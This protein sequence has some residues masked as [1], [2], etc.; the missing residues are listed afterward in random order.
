MENLVPL[1]ES[2]PY[3]AIIVAAS[4]GG[5]VFTTWLKIKHG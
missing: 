2:L 5:W 1:L 4:I 3:V